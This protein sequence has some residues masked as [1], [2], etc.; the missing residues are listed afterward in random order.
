M[1]KRARRG[2]HRRSAQ[3]TLVLL[4]VA[5]SIPV[6]GMG[7]HMASSTRVID[8]SGSPTRVL[9]LGVDTRE[10]GEA[11]LVLFGAAG[12]P[13]EA[14][15]TWPKRLATLSP[16]VA[17]D[18]PGIG[19]S[20]F[21]GQAPTPERVVEHAHEMLAV[22]DL[23]P[24][25]VLVGWSWGG[26][27]IRQYSGAYPSDVAGLVYLDPTDMEA[28]PAEVAGASS[29][30][31]LADIYAE[32]DAVVATRNM[33]PAQNAERRVITQFNRS[34]VAER[35]LPDDLAVPTIVVLATRVPDI[36]SGAPSYVTGRGMRPCTLVEFGSSATGRSVNRTLRW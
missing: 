8:V 29:S 32:L 21:D 34:S 23:A 36:P 3:L 30:E 19:G 17:Y 31:E 25:Y 2:D 26:P 35:G 24:P 16:V 27:R 18:R 7:Q 5:A 15:G 6:R 14:W 4:V 28:T 13:L 33:S 1:M 22:L 11:V 9:T 20:P 10:Q 12:A